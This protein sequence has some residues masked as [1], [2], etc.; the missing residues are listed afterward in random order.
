MNN[1]TEPPLTLKEIF[2]GNIDDKNLNLNIIKQ[3][4]WG[5]EDFNHEES[6]NLNSLE[7]NLS[8]REINT[9]SIEIPEIDTNLKIKNLNF[10]TNINANT[11]INKPEIKED[12][13]LK[14]PDINSDLNINH[15][16]EIGNDIDINIPQIQLDVKNKN[17][18]NENSNDK[19]IP[20]KTLKD[21]FSK[22][23][24]DDIFHPKLL[25]NEISADFQNLAVNKEEK[26]KSLNL[27]DDLDNNI[28]FKEPE[29][30]IPNIKL[31]GKKNNLNMKIDENVDNNDDIDV[32]DINIKKEEIN[33]KV[34]LPKKDKNK[35]IK[36][37]LTLKELFGDDVD[38]DNYLDLNV[39]NPVLAPRNNTLYI[40]GNK[41]DIKL[42][43]SDDVSIKGPNIGQQLYQLNN[44]KE[45]PKKLPSYSN[46][47]SGS[48]IKHNI[49]YNFDKKIKL[50]EK[51]IDLRQE[52]ANNV[53]NKN[54]SLNLE[55]KVESNLESLNYD[56]NIKED[57]VPINI[58]INYKMITNNN[59]TSNKSPSKQKEIPNDFHKTITLR[60]LFNMGVNAPF[61]LTNTHIDYKKENKD[62]E[63]RSPRQDDIKGSNNINPD[64]KFKNIDNNNNEEEQK[65][66]EDNNNNNDPF[67]LIDLV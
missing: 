49:P 48:E 26:E 53:L 63:I 13:N 38:N 16:A 3:D 34:D 45:L 30:E 31:K 37:N 67:D 62:D 46:I 47:S 56:E 40:S 18:N 6:N 50:S 12:I 17:V 7:I 20:C 9:P 14:I 29:I 51:E 1:L 19:F 4:L 39:V 55:N 11:N 60:E 57:I 23:I 2:S 28:D 24:N 33:L 44:K 32:P 42:Y 52:V 5:N 36:K 64:K 66:K 15:K 58:D 22:D 35:E 8:N 59:D 61:N 65:K 25:K 41:D 21:I 54:P 10:N 43:P 27:F